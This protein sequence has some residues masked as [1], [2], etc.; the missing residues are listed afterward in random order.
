LAT[1]LS[2]LLLA[3]L[4]FFSNKRARKSVIEK[5]KKNI[6]EKDITIFKN[7]KMAE[8]GEDLF[9]LKWND[10]NEVLMNSFHRL[11]KTGQVAFFFGLL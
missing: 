3:C 4:C 9:F 1:P 6:T 7:Y 10:Y 2:K 8:D 11:R 5:G